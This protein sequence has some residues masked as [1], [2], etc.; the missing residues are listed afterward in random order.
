MQYF[1]VIYLFIR[2]AREEEQT[3]FPVTLKFVWATVIFGRFPFR[4]RPPPRFLKPE[5]KH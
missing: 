2:F 5:G 3:R 1:H 4:V